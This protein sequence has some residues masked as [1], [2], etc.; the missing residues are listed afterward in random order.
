MRLNLFLPVVL[1]TASL[2]STPGFAQAPPRRL[3]PPWWC[4]V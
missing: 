3:E 4:A 1:M 2:A